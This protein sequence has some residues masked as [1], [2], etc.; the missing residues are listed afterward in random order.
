MQILFLLWR[1]EYSKLKKNNTVVIISQY[2]QIPGHC[3]VHLKLIQCYM[4]LISKFSKIGE[5]GFYLGSRKWKKAL[6]TSLQWIKK[7]EVFTFA[8]FLTL[9]WGLI[10]QG[11]LKVKKINAP[12]ERHD[13]STGLPEVSSVAQSC[14]TLCDPISRSTPGLPVHHQLPEFT[15]THAHRVSDACCCCCC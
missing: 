7:P 11:Y 3:V 12:K 1:Y 4:S 15:Q 13:I 5:S 8:T 14:P 9:I 10:L 2:I 6:L